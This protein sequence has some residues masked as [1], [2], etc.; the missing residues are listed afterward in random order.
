MVVFVN[1]VARK[2]AAQDFREHIVGVIGRH[3]A[4][5]VF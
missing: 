5:R 4:P 1:L 2:F 3:F